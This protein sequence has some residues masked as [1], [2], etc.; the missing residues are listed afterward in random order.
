MD[1]AIHE[2]FT[3]IDWAVIFGYLIL[4][5]VVGHIMRGKQGTIRDFFLG[6]RS[7]PWQ[8]VCGSIIAT[9]ISGVTFI[10]VAGTLFALKGDFTYLLWGIG[11]VIGRV[12]VAL[13]F[14]PKYYED[15]IYSPYDYMGKRLG[16]GVKKLATIVFTVGSILG[17]SVRVF[18]AAIPLEVVTGLP[19]WICIIIIGLFAIG[20]TLMGGMRT[21]IWTDVM[22]FGL[23]TLGGL[24]ALFWVVSSLDGGWAEYWK[25][26]EHYGRTNV[27]DGRWGFDATMKF[28]FWVAILAVPFQNLTAFGVDQLNAQRMFC[29][30]D[31]KAA[32]KALIW[33]SA[34][35]LLTLLMLLVG[36][37]LFV[38]YDK[39]PFEAYE[40]REVMGITKT[41]DAEA[42]ALIA[43]KALDEAPRIGHP[44]VPLEHLKPGNEGEYADLVSNVAK[45]SKPDNVFPM[46]I[47]T[48]LPVGLSGLILAGIFAAAISSLDSILA[49]LSQTTLSFIYHPEDRTDEELEELNLVHKSRMLVVMWGILLTAFTLLLVIAAQGIPVVP[50]AFGMTAY[51]MGPLLAL[52]LCSLM[53]KGSLRGLIIGAVVSFMVTMFGRM[54]IWVLVKKAGVSI[55]WLLSLP[56][57]RMTSGGELE[58]AFCFAW[59]WPLTTV[60][61]ITFGL[62]VPRK[63]KISY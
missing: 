22:Q 16:V 8:A 62:L 34:G 61:T 37:A 50:L 2:Y 48:Q 21:V 52:F 49:A 35:Q 15:E 3:L 19:I 26:A 56:T 13:Y 14:V 4:T 55:D 10:G 20:W 53:G 39:H 41:L 57:Y 44:S 9:E 42:D 54:D 31:A 32:A 18:V 30:K 1:K 7:L 27:W 12:V 45:P 43:Q 40:G 58:A 36:A 23:F 51:T 46:W 5:T 63:Q 6:G 29:C 33:S 38:H 47:V 59:F 25:V 28:T 24:T 60:I 11:S 17:Q